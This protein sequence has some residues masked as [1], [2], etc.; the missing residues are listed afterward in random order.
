MKRQSHRLSVRETLKW[1]CFPSKADELMGMRG[2]SDIY[3][4]S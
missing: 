1:F 3:S 4:G 2:M